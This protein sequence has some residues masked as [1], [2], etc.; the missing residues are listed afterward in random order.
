MSDEKWEEKKG[1][2][3][4]CSIRLFSCDIL[5]LS[6]WVSHRSTGSNKQAVLVIKKN[7]GLC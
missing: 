2:V 1:T 3:F 6:K 7:S 5:S 4:L